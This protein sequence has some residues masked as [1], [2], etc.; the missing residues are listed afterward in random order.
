VPQKSTGSWLKTCSRR[1][2]TRKARPTCSSLSQEPDTESE[3]DLAALDFFLGF[4]FRSFFTF[5]ADGDSESE[6]SS[7]V[8]LSPSV[9][10]LR[11][12]RLGS[13]STFLCFFFLLL[14]SSFWSV[15]SANK[16]ASRFLHRRCP[17]LYNAQN[18]AVYSWDNE[19]KPD[20]TERLRKQAAKPSTVSRSFSL[21]NF[22]EDF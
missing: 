12:D 15:A 21:S 14:S 16:V 22:A 20:S 19:N 13:A 8:D 9:F 4:P 7:V 6:S 5:L 18:N 2:Q 17:E 3:G 10:F 11:A 1:L